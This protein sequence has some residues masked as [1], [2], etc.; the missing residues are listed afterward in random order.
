VAGAVEYRQHYEGLINKQEE[1]QSAAAY[2][3]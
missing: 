2:D 3:E 1:D